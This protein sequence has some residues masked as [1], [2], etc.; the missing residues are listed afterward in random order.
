MVS[1]VSPGAALETYEHNLDDLGDPS[2]TT[3]KNCNFSSLYTANPVDQEFL[4]GTQ[5]LLSTAWKTIY[6]NTKKCLGEITITF[7]DL[8]KS[9]LM[10]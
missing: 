3:S 8:N 9:M 10:K 7:T 2:N 1:H 5:C 4:G 6:N